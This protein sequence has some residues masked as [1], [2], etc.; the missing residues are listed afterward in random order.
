M[1]VT[2]DNA[3]RLVLPKEIR[4]Q[5]HIEAGTPLDISFRDDHIEIEPAPRQVKIVKRRKLSVAVATDPSAALTTEVVRK[6][7]DHIRER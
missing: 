5:A 7:R 2:I 4:E 3:G 6:T 1:I